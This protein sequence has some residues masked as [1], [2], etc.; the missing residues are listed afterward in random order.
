MKHYSLILSLS[1][2]MIFAT[3]F[4]ITPVKGAGFVV[5][6]SD[7]TADGSCTL[8][9]CSLREAI[10][11]ANANSG[12]DTI[13]I[14]AGTYTL[15]QAGREED[16]AVRGD[17][18][19]SDDVIITGA[20]PGQTIINGNQLDRV[21]DLRNFLGINVEIE[22]VTIYNGV[23]D[24][25]GGGIII[26]SGTTLQL[27][28]SNVISN[29]S[30]S[31]QGGGGIYIQ[32][33]G[34]LT[35]SHSSVV[36]NTAVGAGGGINNNNQ[37]FAKNSTISRNTGDLGGGGLYNNNVANLNN[38]TIAENQ[39][40][41]LG[42]GIRDITGNVTL[43]N[44]LLADNTSNGSPSDCSTTSSLIS[45]G[46]NLIES[47]SGCTISG[48]TTGNI[49]NQAAQLLPLILNGQ[50]TWSHPL[51][52]TSPAVDA[53]NPATPGSTSTAC[54]TTDQQGFRRPLDGNGDDTAQCDIGA[55]E[56]GQESFLPVVSK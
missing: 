43:Q 36:S 3:I 25:S 2:A 45:A 47:T 39:T 40:D 46:Y 13:T 1:L 14:P 22:G 23:V 49:T 6:K 21:F 24:D 19:I 27:T 31:D 32:G 33:T 42:G 50:A 38:V 54:Q 12:L 8:T 37:L 7:D 41:N 30:T 28:N 56:V 29:S 52:S 48:D 16:V 26:R 5:T 11:A 34:V 17:L 53:G 55:V 51:G 9:D 10:I 44:T 35:L 4:F 15:T 20:G 18:D